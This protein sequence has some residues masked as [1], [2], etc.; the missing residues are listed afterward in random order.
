MKPPMTENL[1]KL[2]MIRCVLLLCHDV[3]GGLFPFSNPLPAADDVAFFFFASKS[4][5]VLQL[6]RGTANNE[7]ASTALLLGDCNNETPLRKY[8]MMTM[9]VCISNSRCG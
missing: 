1:G 8:N 3:V 7:N 4:S 2:L 9:T 5:E 6:L